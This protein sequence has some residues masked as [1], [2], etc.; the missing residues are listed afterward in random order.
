MGCIVK[1]SRA[2]RILLSELLKEEVNLNV[3]KIEKYG[4]QTLARSSQKLIT[5]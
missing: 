4:L 2:D 5:V 3:S 1:K